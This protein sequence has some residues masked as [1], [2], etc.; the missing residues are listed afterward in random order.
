MNRKIA[1]G[2]TAALAVVIGGGAYALGTRDDDTVTQVTT[3][4]APLVT[5]ASAA[6]GPSAAPF[7]TRSKAAV[8]RSPSAGRTSPDPAQVRREIEAARSTA[9]KDGYPLQRPLSA[10]PQPRIGAE[11]ARTYVEETRPLPD[12]GTMRIMSARYDL[13]GQREMLWAADT[14]TEAGAARCTQNF[15]FA[16]GQTPRV[17][18]T[19]L[20]CWRNTA[21]RSV[22]V[23]A[24]ARTDAPDTTQVL[25]VLDTQWNR[26]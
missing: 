4:D 13:S 21:D 19:M 2:A 10:A 14:G 25:N 24:V 6:P 22:V 11:D 26:L 16:R 3:A 20:L 8:K 5:P 17:R 7:G 18:K 12:G 1:I 9:A 15:R 23:L